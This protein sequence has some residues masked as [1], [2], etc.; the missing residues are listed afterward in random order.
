MMT[1]FQEF[2]RVTGKDNFCHAVCDLSKAHAQPSSANKSQILYVKL[3]LVVRT[4]KAL[5]S[6][7]ALNAGSPEPSLCANVIST[8]FTLGDPVFCLL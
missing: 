1:D 3:P 5:G 2:S 4:A 8:L 6:E 7:S